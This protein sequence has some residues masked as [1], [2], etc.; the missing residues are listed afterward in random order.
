MHA[1]CTVEHDVGYGDTDN[2]RDASAGV[3]EHA[4]EQVVALA[5]PA[6]TRCADERVDLFTR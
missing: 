6:R 3:L 5:D 4:Q 1:R 2:L